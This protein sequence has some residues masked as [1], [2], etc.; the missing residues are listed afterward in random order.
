MSGS[1]AGLGGAVTGVG[2]LFLGL[3]FLDSQM[4]CIP[5]RQP[6]SFACINL[7]KPSPHLISSHDN[8]H[9]IWSDHWQ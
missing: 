1:S 6:A 7:Q 3:S 2:R 5:L 9:D 8:D 4:R